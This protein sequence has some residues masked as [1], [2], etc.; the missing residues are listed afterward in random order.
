MRMIRSGDWKLCYYHGHRS[1]LFNLAE[2]P[3]ELHDRAQ[4]P[5]CREVREQLTARVL[6]GWDPEWVGEQLAIKRREREIIRTWGQKVRPPD[7]YRWAMRPGMSYL[8][9][10][11]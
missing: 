5:A 11:S 2:D 3:Q 6:D 7:R 8:D 4:D 1:Q 10:D 9:A